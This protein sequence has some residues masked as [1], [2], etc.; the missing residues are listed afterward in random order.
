[1]LNSERAIKTSEE[2]EFLRHQPARLSREHSPP[3]LP[4]TIGTTDAE[5]SGFSESCRRINP[6]SKAFLCQRIVLI[7][8]LEELKHGM[9]LGITEKLA[10]CSSQ[11]RNVIIIFLSATEAKNRS[12]ERRVG[13]ECRL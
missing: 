6:V 3:A 2:E 9:T 13:K 12:E 5:R 4:N 1:M 7:Q 11:P 10:I 8:S